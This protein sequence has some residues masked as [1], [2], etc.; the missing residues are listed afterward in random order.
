MVQN[1]IK[2]GQLGYALELLGDLD[3]MIVECQENPQEWQNSWLNVKHRYVE[4]REWIREH[5]ETLIRQDEEPLIRVAM[6]RKPVQRPVTL[7]VE[8]VKTDMPPIR[9]DEEDAINALKDLNSKE[10]M[11]AWKMLMNAIVLGTQ[12]GAH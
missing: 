4:V 2:G 9:Q 10:P 7:A 3:V 1:Y 6:G 11:E 5:T 12:T 8:P